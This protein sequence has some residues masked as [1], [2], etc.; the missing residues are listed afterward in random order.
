MTTKGTVRNVRWEEK[1]FLRYLDW[2]R[3]LYPTAREVDLDEVVEYHKTVIGVRNFPEVYRRAREENRILMQPR[4]GVATIDG[5]IEAFRYLVDET[6]VDLLTMSCDTYTR[7]LQ[8]KQAERGL[9]ESLEQGR[10]MLNGFPAVLHGVQGTRRVVESVDQ[11]VGGRGATATPQLYNTIMLA[12]GAT[13]F[14]GSALAFALNCDARTPILD[15]IHNAQFVDRLLGYLQERG[16]DVC[17]ESSTIVSGT[18]VPPSIAV[19]CGVLEI[20]LAAEQGVKHHCVA[21]P[22]NSAMVQDIAG[23]RVLKQ[24]CRS[25]ADDFGYTDVTITPAVHHWLGP[26]PEDRARALARISFDSAITAYA[27]VTKVL[28]KSPEEGLG[29]PTKEGTAEGLNAT[30]HVLDMLRGQEFPQSEQMEEEA[31]IIGREAKAILD[32]VMELGSGDLAAGISQA[33]QTGV[34]EFPYSVN[35]HNAGKTLVARDHTRAVRFLDTGNLPFDKEI[36][37]YHRRK[38]VEQRRGRD[39]YE[40]VIE[41]IRAKVI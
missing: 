24:M 19:V 4:F 35:M 32:A 10:S 40:L 1:E 6:D 16:A 18:I 41:D 33:F 36:V 2:V 25:Y 29:T 12:G 15:A 7:R 28:V 27:G 11:P 9:Q 30:R 38:M 26:F 37:E 13:E 23:I 8:F 14:N 17:K 21:Y 22:L 31:R 39:D 3:S 34:L 5:Q 20:L